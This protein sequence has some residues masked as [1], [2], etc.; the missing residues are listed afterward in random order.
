MP[1]VHVRVAM[2]GVRLEFSGREAFFQQ[3]VAALVAAVYGDQA[4]PTAANGIATP[5]ASADLNVAP[6]S[7]EAA[8]RGSEAVAP[9]A[10]A[11][12]DTPTGF[13]PSSGRFGKFL[14]QVGARAQNET[15]QIVA[16]AFYLWNSEE[17]RHFSPA[18]IQGCFEAIGLDGPAD[19]DACLD[20]LMEKKRFIQ[21][22]GIDGDYELT[23]KG[24]NYVKTRLLTDV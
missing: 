11:G 23:Q 14:G 22:V 18:Q 4:G 19:L 20:D 21:D 5:E 1:S 24:I 8:G 16:F 7:T 15:Q 3:H 13:V 17:R 10:P 2:R 12:P 9:E 6:A